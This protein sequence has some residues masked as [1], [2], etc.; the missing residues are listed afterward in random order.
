LAEL[1][2]LVTV[3]QVP[4][5]HVEAGG[6]QGAPV[7]GKRHTAYR[8]GVAGQGLAELPQ[9]ITVGQIPQDGGLVF[10][11]GGEDTPVAGNH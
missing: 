6:G 4:Q 8:G 11:A 1:A 7:W 2:G 3:G 5:P 9:L 10:A